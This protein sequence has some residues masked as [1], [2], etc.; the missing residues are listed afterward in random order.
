MK[1]E[2]SYNN[3]K[4]VLANS[5]K[6]IMKTKSF[7]KISVSEIILDSGFNRKTF[8]Y[9]FEDIYDLL[10]WIFE[11]EAIEIVKKFD[12]INDYEKAI[13]FVMDYIEKNDY[14]INCAYDA[15]GRDEMKRFF[16]NDF[17]NIILSIIERVENELDIYL[18]NEY[19]DF[20]CMFYTEALAGILIRWIKN[21]K[22]RNKQQVI[23][24]FVTTLRV[25]LI[26]IIKE[27][28]MF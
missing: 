8:Y 22:N 13:L 14:I 11:N 7:S 21:R 5:L 1:H 9:H 17:Y 16:V 18:D 6:K 28:S 27:Y 25:S 10:K 20:L 26:N 19:K 2:T 3:T 4:K 24:Y 23:D 15:I 12:L